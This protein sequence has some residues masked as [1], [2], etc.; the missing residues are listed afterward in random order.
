MNPEF[1]AVFTKFQQQQ[2][3]A[4]R[5]FHEEQLKI[6]EEMLKEE[7]K[8]QMIPPKKRAHSP[9][10]LSEE[11]QPLFVQPQPLVEEEPEKKRK[12][13][14]KRKRP[15]PK[16]NGK[17]ISKT[18]CDVDLGN[19]CYEKRKRSL[20]LRDCFVLLRDGHLNDFLDSFLIRRE[21]GI[22]YELLGKFGQG[23]T[24][25]F[26][27]NLW[28]LLWKDQLKIFKLKE[29]QKGICCA[30][31]LPRTLT[32]II[33]EKVETS[34]DYPKGLKTLGIMGCDCYEFKFSTLVNLVRK[35]KQIA[36]NVDKEDFHEYARKVL[37]YA[38]D[39]IRDSGTDMRV[40]YQYM[41]K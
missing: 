18:T 8:K 7:L 19:I 25:D 41:T 16:E 30:C 14:K 27:N 20:T 5:K 3:E 32:Y 17:K 12:Q 11:H 36:Q 40:K 28:M 31:N 21:F 22:V 29:P 15:S 39:K 13:V 37:D 24:K 2:D 1:N 34:T 6:F 9:P 26:M 4:L 10:P 23:Y 33:R 35:C 38:I